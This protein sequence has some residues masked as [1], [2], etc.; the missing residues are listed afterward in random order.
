MTS[1][2]SSSLTISLNAIVC[3][4]FSKSLSLPG[5]RNGYILISPEAKE[6][7]DLIAAVCGAGRALGYICAP[8]LLQQLIKTCLGKTADISV[9]DR[10]RTLLYEAL[11]EYGYEAVY[12]DGAFYLFVKA[13]EE[14]ANTFCEKVKAFDLLIVPADSFGC[15][16]YVRI[17]YCVTTQQIQ[18]SLPAFKKLA[19][20]YIKEDK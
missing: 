16:G 1:G 3:Y 7:D 2:A 19:E 13:L 17:A 11:T 14:D 10:N 12:P 4:S 20:A 5:E 18:R 15:P 8:S 9:Y 6:S